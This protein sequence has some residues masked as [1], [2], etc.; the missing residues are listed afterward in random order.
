MSIHQARKGWAVRWREDGRHRSLTFATEREATDFDRA[1][2]E[3]RQH[4]R[5]QQR[6]REAL[7]RIKR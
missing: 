7:Q 6:V 1:L 3:T 4:E 2:R 5:Q